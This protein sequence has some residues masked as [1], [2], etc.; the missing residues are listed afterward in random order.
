MI[1]Y[2]KGHITMHF[3]GGVVIESNG[4]G[5]EVFVPG[6]SPAYAYHI[7]QHGS[8]SDN[9]ILLYTVM[10]V[11]E[12]DISLYGFTEKDSMSLFKLLLS[13]NGVGAKAAMSML[14]AM[15]PTEVRK[16][17][18]FEDVTS[19]CKA[20]GIGK[21]I[22]QRV[23]LELKDKIGNLVG[24]NDGKSTDFLNSASE[25]SENDAKTEAVFALMA[26]GYSRTEASEAIGK[27]S[28]E[29]DE[30]VEYYIK[31]ALKNLK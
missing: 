29:S 26:L 28:T 13:V 31:M 19:L 30:T 17:I 20:Q 25:I 4:I 3:D 23:V 1:H 22:A 27:I 9:E 21:K 16:S 12:D 6:S 7:S 11:R 5:Y 15:S 8:N 18:L 2:I 24:I 14:S 10:M